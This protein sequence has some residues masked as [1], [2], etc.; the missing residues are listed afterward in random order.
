MI[1]F[2]TINYYSTLLLEQL[3]N[4]LPPIQN[5]AYQIVIVN[6]SPQDLSVQKLEGESIKILEANANLGFASGCNLGLNWIYARDPDAIVWI[7]NP[8]T[9]LQLDSWERISALF[10]DHP[11]LSIVGTLIYTPEQEIWFAGGKFIPSRGAIFSTN[12]LFSHPD[13]SYVN[14]DW[15]SACSLLINLRRFPSC[16]QFD[17]AYFLYY[18]D[19]DFCQRYA[20]QGHQIAITNR[21]SIV[22]QP[23]SIT[24]RNIAQKLKHSTYSYLLTLEKYTNFPI[25]GLRLLRLIG[26]TFILLFVNPQMAFGKIAGIFTYLR[27]SVIK[28]SLEQ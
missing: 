3:I 15:V 20:R 19:F 14:C 9:Y 22:H 10:S 5:L 12:L 4:S 8:D 6:N 7:I 1:Y 17:P 2:L 26:Y 16:P 11:H 28:L 13:S 18:E 25:F 23:S 24:N 27:G 21:L